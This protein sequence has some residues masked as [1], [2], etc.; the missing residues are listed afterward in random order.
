M[1]TM[2]GLA[3]DL[4]D[5]EKL[6]ELHTILSSLGIQEQELEELNLTKEILLNSELKDLTRA[7]RNNLNLPLSLQ[8]K[9]LLAIGT[10][11]LDT[12]LD[13][14]IA[15]ACG[16][17]GNRNDNEKSVFQ[18]SPASSTSND[19]KQEKPIK[20]FLHHFF[21]SPWFIKEADSCSLP[22]S[23]KCC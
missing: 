4:P 1:Y 7:Q 2:K 18:M 20:R 3:E 8:E 19:N 15:T 22:P 6:E 23:H 21:V 17:V 12:I 10:L 16:L 14:R 5:R 13:L 9:Q 11:T